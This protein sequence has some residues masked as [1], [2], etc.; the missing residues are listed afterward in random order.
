M[1]ELTPPDEIS[2]PSIPGDMPNTTNEGFYHGREVLEEFPEL[3]WV[4]YTEMAVLAVMGL[5]GT[6]GNGLIILVQWKTKNKIGTDLLVGTMALFDFFDSSVN[7]V[8]AILYAG[9]TKLIIS[10]MFC[11]FLVMMVYFTAVTTALFIG[12]I[13]VDRYVLTCKPLNKVYTM[14][15]TKFLCYFPAVIGGIFSLP[16]FIVVEYNPNILRCKYL[17]NSTGYFV[18][19]IWNGVTVILVAGVFILTSIAYLNIT[20]MLRRRMKRR[21]KASEAFVLPQIKINSTDIDN[22]SISSSSVK[23][24]NVTGPNVYDKTVSKF[25]S[26]TTFKTIPMTEDRCGQS[27]PTNAQVMDTQRTRCQRMK[28]KTMNRTTKVL[29]F[30]SLIYIISWATSSFVLMTNFNTNRV[31]QRLLYLVRRVNIVTNPLLFV[32][33]SSK[34]KEGVKKF[35]S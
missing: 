18:S 11:K 4:D 27:K 31:V 9:F 20:L 28:E 29:F 5:L 22:T 12:V 21:L 16:H 13:A 23:E 14:R 26:P 33:M 3:D 19:S 34:F 30:I 8:M 2:S 7:T 32:L 15:V 25:R 1:E 24:S 6:P 17:E 10:T 35:F